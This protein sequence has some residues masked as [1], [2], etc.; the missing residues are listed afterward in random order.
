MDSS[1]KILDSGFF[2][3]RILDS[4]GYFAK[5]SGILDSLQ[6]GFWDSRFFAERILDSSGFFAKYSR[7]RILG[8]W[9]LHFA[10]RLHSI[11]QI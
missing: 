10:A 3:K 1:P 7:K 11:L 4:S 6:K 8:F 5:D 2:A 9:I